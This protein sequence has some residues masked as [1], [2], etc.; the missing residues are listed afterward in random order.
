MTSYLYRKSHCGDKTILRPS[1]LHNGIS[2]TCK[3]T[4]LYWIRAQV[5]HSWSPFCCV[6]H[7]RGLLLM[8]WMSSKLMRAASCEWYNIYIYLDKYCVQHLVL[9][10]KDKNYCK[11]VLTHWGRVTH[12]CLSKL[13]IIGS[14]NGLA[15]GRCQAI[16]RT[17]SG[18]LLIGALGTN[19][20]EILSKIHTFSFIKWVWKCHLWKR[21]Q[22]CLGLNVLRAIRLNSKP[23]WSAA[24]LYREPAMQ[25]KYYWH[26]NNVTWTSTYLN[27]PAKIHCLFNGLYRPTTKK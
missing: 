18:I 4:S 15:P 17:N 24:L 2:Y 7:H 20:C 26:Y 25:W 8:H 1:Y 16:F 12:I 9:D 6:D 11:W 19:F 5:L 3:T 13:T 21:L 27:L 10:H 22:F 14:D 23:A